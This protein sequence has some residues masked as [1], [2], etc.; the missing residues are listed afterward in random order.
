MRSR[1]VT[2]GGGERAEK[3]EEEGA[4]RERQR[5]RDRE[6]ERDRERQRGR[7]RDRE[8][9]R[10]TERQRE[11]ERGRERGLTDGGP[12][13]LHGAERAVECGGGVG[14]PPGG[15]E[16]TRLLATEG[17]SRSHRTRAAH[18]GPHKGL[19]RARR[20][21]ETRGHVGDGGVEARAAGCAHY[22]AGADG[23]LAR[24]A[25]ETCALTGGGLIEA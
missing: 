13:G 19:E 7:E 8:A 21:C 22:G 11:R 18:S 24:S 12:E 2:N 9:E 15:A 10:E 25:G 4:D 6:A 14:E 23:V 16:R 5:G 20:A 17:I 1:R 3:G